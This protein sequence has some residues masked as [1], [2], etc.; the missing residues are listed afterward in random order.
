MLSEAERAAF[1]ARMRV[2]C[3]TNSPRLRFLEIFRPVLN[4]DAVRNIDNVLAQSDA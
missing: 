3:Q 2:T 1:D 4:E